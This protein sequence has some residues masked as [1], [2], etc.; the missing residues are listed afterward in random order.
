[1]TTFPTI[2]A[3][4][5]LTKCFRPFRAAGGVEANVAWR[6]IRERIYGDVTVSTRN[7]TA[8]C[9]QTMADSLETSPNNKGHQKPDRALRADRS[10]ATRGLTA[11]IGNTADAARAVIRQR[12][13]NT[14]GAASSAMV[15]VDSVH[16]SSLCIANSESS[17]HA[18][19]TPAVSTISAMTPIAQLLA[20]VETALHDVES[21]IASAEE[22]PLR[23]PSEFLIG[24]AAMYRRALGAWRA[25]ASRG[26]GQESVL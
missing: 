1:M 15:E 7:Q 2:T 8:S 13:A 25:E 10:A 23:V 16:P 19:S 24:R 18:G 17:E 20:A 26:A 12:A 4:D 9:R 5:W 11:A 14:M 22:S 6:R 3:Q 21:E